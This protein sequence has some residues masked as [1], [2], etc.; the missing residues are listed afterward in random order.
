MAIVDNILDVSHSP[1]CLAHLSNH[2]LTPL[3]L[4]ED[5]TYALKV[6]APFL[7]IS[8]T[9]IVFLVFITVLDLSPWCTYFGPDSWIYKTN[10]HFPAGLRPFCLF[11]FEAFFLL[12][13]VLFFVGMPEMARECTPLIW[14]FI[15]LSIIISLLQNVVRLINLAKYDRPIQIRYF[16]HNGRTSLQCRIGVFLLYFF[17]ELGLMVGY[18]MYQ[19]HGVLFDILIAI[20]LYGSRSVLFW[21][22]FEASTRKRETLNDNATRMVRE[23]GT[24]DQG[25]NQVTIYMA[26]IESATAE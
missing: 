6:F 26:P 12:A 23:D 21:S 22:F 2:H 13:T 7:F 24:V 3:N 17:L 20:I 25:E 1:K 14:Y 4:E 10:K 16:D 18:C 8:S 11:G 15:I 19:S 9:L 5:L